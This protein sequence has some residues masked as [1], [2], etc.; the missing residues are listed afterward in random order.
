MRLTVLSVLTGGL[1][2]FAGAF[3]YGQPAKLLSAGGGT[4]LLQQEDAAKIQAVYAGWRDAVRN[5]EIDGYLKVL[6]KDVRLLPPNAAAIQG[7]D[8]YAQF[9]SAGI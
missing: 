1:L 5:S 3:A 6:H 7:R 2:L 4:T 9:F 8:N